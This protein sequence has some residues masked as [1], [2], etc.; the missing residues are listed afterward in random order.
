MNNSKMKYLNK[1][2]M[3]LCKPFKIL[4]HLHHQAK[5]RG[6]AAAAVVV[7][8]EWGVAVEDETMT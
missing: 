1:W 8:E 3:F 7:E 2:K 5:C 4:L 6:E